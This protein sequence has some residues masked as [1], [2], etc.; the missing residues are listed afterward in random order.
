[1][2]QD[3]HISK[4]IH[5]KIE[6]ELSRIGIL[7]RVFSRIKTTKSLETKINKVKGKYSQDGKKIQDIFG[8]RVALYF[9][10]DREIAQ[11]AIEKVFDIDKISST[12][13]MPNHSSFEATRHNLI[14][15]LTDELIKD[16]IIC[17]KEPLVDTTFE[18]QLRTI[19]SEGWHEVEHDLR[20]KHNEDWN[21]HDDLNRALNGIYASLETADWSMMKVFEELS[22]RHYK[23]EEWEQMLRTKFRIRFSGSLK[24]SIQT[25]FTEN[26]NS[27]K[28]IFQIKRVK[29]IKLI[30]EKNIEI[31]LTYDNLVHIINFYYLKDEQLSL[32]CPEP[33]ISHL[34]E[35]N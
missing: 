29:L 3:I 4:E 32:E 7:F 30:T 17:Q 34:E 28:F 18:V 11:I 5:K 23:S 8:V 24:Q 16:C 25:Y 6:K 26:H 27:I 2:Q 33:I 9:P 10:D 14:F 12:I 19:L 21:E 15:K 35:R 31:P 22:Y 20:Y 13:D 1:M